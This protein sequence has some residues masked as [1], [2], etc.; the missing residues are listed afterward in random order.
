MKGGFDTRRRAAIERARNLGLRIQ[1]DFPEVDNLYRSGLTYFE[2]VDKLNLTN[3]YNVSSRTTLKAALCFSRIGTEHYPGLSQETL[4]EKVTRRKAKS[5][6]G[7]KRLKELGLG[8]HAATKEQLR[9]WS[10]K[11]ILALGFK[12]YSDEEIEYYQHLKNQNH[13]SRSEIANMINSKFWGGKPVRS[14]NSMDYLKR[15]TSP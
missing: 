5:R 9:D 2:I 3:Y 6:F 8:I 12:P 13:T 4:E 7:Q 11:G 15:I 1:C 10:T 14:I